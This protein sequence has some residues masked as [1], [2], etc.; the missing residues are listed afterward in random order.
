MILAAQLL[1]ILAFAVHAIAG[2]C[3]HHDHRH[4]YCDPAESSPA[5]AL[6]GATASH[7]NCRHVHDGHGHHQDDVPGDGTETSEE[8]CHHDHSCQGHCTYLAGKPLKAPTF[9]GCILLGNA[10]SRGTLRPAFV[11]AVACGPLTPEWEARTPASRCA[12]LQSWQI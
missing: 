5:T 1:T 7:E 12:L 9:A 10:D 11:S 6:S 8:P 3:A 2:C 4:C